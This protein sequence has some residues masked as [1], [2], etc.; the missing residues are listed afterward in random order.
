MA[1]VPSLVGLFLTPALTA[2][3]AS[4]LLAT[5]QQTY[6]PT[7]LIGEIVSQNPAAGLTV[8]AGTNIIITMSVGVAPVAGNGFDKWGATGGGTTAVNM[9]APLGQNLSSAAQPENAVYFANQSVMATLAKGLTIN[10]NTPAYQVPVLPLMGAFGFPSSDI[11]F[12]Y[13]YWENLTSIPVPW[14]NGLNR[15]TQFV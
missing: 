8:P 6:T 12:A 3:V 5:L 14:I 7:A 13:P 15:P 1:T 2:L 9:P 4:G 11:F 10:Q